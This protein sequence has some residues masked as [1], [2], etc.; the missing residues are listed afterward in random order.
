MENSWKK[1][2][3]KDLIAENFTTF[4]LTKFIETIT[5]DGKTQ[6]EIELIVQDYSIES[7]KTQS[8]IGHTAIV[9]WRL[10]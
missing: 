10:Y 7:Y 9:Q 1:N 5:I 2:H 4:Y 8:L 6:S 3:L